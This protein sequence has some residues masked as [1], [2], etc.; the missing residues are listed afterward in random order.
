ME[1][2]DKGDCR[3]D[4]P[5]EKATKPNPEV[6]HKRRL[7]PILCGK[8]HTVST[9]AN[10][11]SVTSGFGNPDQHNRQLVN[12]SPSPAATSAT[13]GLE[14]DLAHVVGSSFIRNY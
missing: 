4:I 3:H 6:Y 14:Q 10:W 9:L 11:C 13:Q 7:P 5:Q 8:R 2:L 12:V 1:V